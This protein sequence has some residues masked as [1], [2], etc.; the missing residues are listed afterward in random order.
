VQLQNLEITSAVEEA[1]NAIAKT[2]KQVYKTKNLPWF[3]FFVIKGETVDVE[4]IYPDPNGERLDVDEKNYVEMVW[5]PMV[6]ALTTEFAKNACYV[7]VDICYTNQ[8]GN[9][10][11]NPVFFKWCPDSGVPVRTKMLIGSGFQSVKKRLDVGGVTPELSQRSQ[12]DF[13]TFG[14]DAKLPGFRG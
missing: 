5:E 7:V 3:A 13:T 8:E 2:N 10:Y 12:L 11:C 4:R 14:T 6:D 1:Y 9:Q